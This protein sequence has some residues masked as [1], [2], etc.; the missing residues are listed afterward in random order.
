MSETRK[1]LTKDLKSMVA[2]AKS[3]GEDSTYLEELLK[4]AEGRSEKGGARER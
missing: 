2:R 4:T 1:E 3:D